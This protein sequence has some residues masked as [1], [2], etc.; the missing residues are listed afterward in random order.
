MFNFLKDKW[1]QKSFVLLFAFT[2]LSGGLYLFF[3]YQNNPVENAENLSSPSK[4]KALSADNPY[5]SI[6]GYDEALKLQAAFVR[7]AKK[8]KPSVVS[9]NNLRAIKKEMPF[10]AFHRNQSTFYH[11]FKTWLEEIS[12]REYEVENLGSGI[13]LDRS[14]HILT[15]YHVI[16][17]AN[18]IMARVNGREYTARIIGTDPTTDLA[19]LKIFSFSNFPEPSFGKSDD[20]DVGEWVMAIGNPYGLE[21]TVTVGV[22]SGKSRSDLGIATYE[23]FLQTDASIN[24]G[25][26]GGPLINL[27]G[28]IIGINTA[29]AALGAGVGFAIPIEMARKIG[30]DLINHGKV[31]RGWIGI[32]IQ[33]VTP[34][35]AASF[36]APFQRGSVIVNKVNGKT[37]AVSAGIKQGDIILQYDDQPVLGTKNFQQLVINTQIGKVVPLKVLRDGR[38]TI[39]EVKIGKLVQ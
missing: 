25:N 29:V 5:S 6:K 3:E 20:V 28:E 9:I 14:G 32:G 30:N 34:E 36:N 39:I 33:P 24:P 23:N 1:I 37:P 4:E 35:L 19:V 26:S 38:E 17:D 10:D 16:E 22:I 13:L 31:E 2:L 12:A 18:H 8:I 7:N 21:G 27:N 15:N 11:Q